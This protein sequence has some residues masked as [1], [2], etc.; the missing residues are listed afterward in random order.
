MH[1][2]AAFRIIGIEPCP[3]SVPTSNRFGG[4]FRTKKSAI[5]AGVVNLA[6]YQQAVAG[7]A[8][9]AMEEAGTWISARPIR[10][11][12]IFL[13]KHR[14]G[15]F[16]GTLWP[17]AVRENLKTGKWAKA[18]GHGYGGRNNPDLTNLVK[19]TEDALEGV[20]FRNDVQVRSQESLML[21][22]PTSGVRVAVYAFDDEDLATIYGD[23]LA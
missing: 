5:P 11:R 16:W 23:D 4:A 20:C 9:H 17:A 3:W 19:A 22:G 2:I 21:Y 14:D 8:R 10:L 15:D 12:L 6:D 18:D 1:L 13:A 7:A